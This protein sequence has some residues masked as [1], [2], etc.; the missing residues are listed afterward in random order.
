MMPYTIVARNMPARI[1]AAMRNL[2]RLI[3]KPVLPYAGA[4]S[5]EPVSRKMDV[6]AAHKLRLPRVKGRNGI[7]CAKNKLNPAAT[8]LVLEFGFEAVY[9]EL[10]KSMV[11]PKR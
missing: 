3:S 1:R 4:R 5:S 8:G 11:H 7:G 10:R 2:R 6:T 9:V